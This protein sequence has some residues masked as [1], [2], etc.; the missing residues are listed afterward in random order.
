[1]TIFVIEVLDSIQIMK[2]KVMSINIIYTK[3]RLDEK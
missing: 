3:Q 2:R 1:M